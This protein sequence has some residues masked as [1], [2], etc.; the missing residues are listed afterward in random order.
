MATNKKILNDSQKMSVDSPYIELFEIDLSKQGGITYYYSG[1]TLDGANITY[2]SNEYPPIPIKIEGMERSA[3][4]Q[5]PRPTLTVSN[6]TRSLLPHIINYNDFLNCTVTVTRLFKKYLDGEGQADTDAHFPS[7]LYRVNRKTKQNMNE[8]I[9]ELISPLDLEYIKIPRERASN[10]C[11]Q[12]YRV[13]D[14]DEFVYT[15]ATCPYTNTDSTAFYTVEGVETTEENDKCG[16]KLV[17][18]K[19]RFGTVNELPMKGF[20][21][22]GANISGF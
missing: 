16:K 19:L 18:C 20:P 14:G 10:M 11:S 5:F 17:D 9:F 15:N 13:W 3:D 7:E 8:V 2:D 22:I 6:I 12:R 21:G 4:G 1:G